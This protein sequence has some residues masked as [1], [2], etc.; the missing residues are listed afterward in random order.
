ME[1]T[2]KVTFRYKITTMKQLVTL[3]ILFFLTSCQSKTD[4]VKNLEN[5]NQGLNV[6]KN[7][8][9]IGG[10]DYAKAIGFFEKSIIDNP[11]HIESKFWKMQ[12]EMKLGKFDN[13]LETSQSAINNARMANHKLIPHFYVAAGLVEIIKGDTIKSDKYFSS[14]IENF[15]SWIKSDINDTDAILN[16]ALALCYMGKKGNAISFLDSITLN[17]GNKI[18]MEQIRKDVLT[19]DFVRFIDNLKGSRKDDN[20]TKDALANE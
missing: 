13:A 3:V 5:Y 12:C 1:T 10:V 20:L 2:K 18:A 7:I 8:D 19:F 4:S 11:D 15:N 9:N 16:K 14:A 17:E 6:M